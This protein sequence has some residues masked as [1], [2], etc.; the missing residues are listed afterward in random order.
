[1]HKYTPFAIMAAVLLPAVITLTLH[2][3]N[4]ANAQG[5]ENLPSATGGE[6]HNVPSAT[7]VEE[8]NMTNAT[9][10]EEHNVTNATGGEEELASCVQIGNHAKC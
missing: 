8:H 3:F 2:T 1:M 7:G 10:V 4:R 9:G 5:N 6:E